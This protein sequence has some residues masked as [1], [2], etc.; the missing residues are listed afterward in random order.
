MR[1]LKSLYLLM[2]ISFSFKNSFAQNPDVL[3]E[4][5]SYDF[6]LRQTL[7]GNVPMGRFAVYP[8]SLKTLKKLDATT[9]DKAFKNYI[10]DYYAPNLDTTSSTDI[11]ILDFY[12]GRLRGAWYADSLLKIQAD[13]GMLIHATSFKS[14]GKDSELMGFGHVSARA[15]GSY[16]DFFEFFFDFSN[17]K[18]TVG[19]SETARI[20]YPFLRRSLKFNIEKQTYFDNYI[21]YVQA[22]FKDLRVRFGR[23]NISH[24][25]SPIDNL[26]FSLKAAPADGLVIDFP[27]KWVR[28]TSTHSMV[29]GVNVLTDEPVSSKFIATHR[30]TVDPANWLSFAFSEMMVYSGRG[31]DFTYLNPVAFLTSAGLG[32]LERSNMDNSLLGFDIAA[33]P[34]KNSMLYGAI[35]V[36]DINFSTLTDN[37]VLGNDNKFAF[38]AGA[39]YL[40][41]DEI[42]PLLLT[43]EYARITPFT[44]AHRRNQN[45]WT[46]Q[47]VP[48]GYDMQPNSDRAAIQLKYWFSPRTSLKIDMDYT[49]HGENLLKADGTILMD[50]T[51]MLPIGNVGGDILRGDGDFLAPNRFLKGNISHSRRV[52]GTLSA[53]FFPNFF[54][55]FS[56]HYESRNGGNKPL[57]QFWGTI[58]LR[59]G[60]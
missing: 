60:Y 53:E 26:I 56:V 1:L 14:E 33:R 58:Q 52:H 37:T 4:P 28:F 50:S 30:V 9:G 55:D 36:D 15:S 21:G 34:F 20:V 25:Y 35:V 22:Q 49:R 59:I 2:L 41:P 6:L 8:L 18:Q 29:E 47:G 7:Q 10:Y 24:G 31:V 16:S 51:G 42:L 5:V 38:Q 3:N 32:S 19:R 45:S 12:R 43:T 39:S 48:L 23:E 46:N 27:Y 44:F 57:Q 54:T 17:G 40:L 13:I 11:H